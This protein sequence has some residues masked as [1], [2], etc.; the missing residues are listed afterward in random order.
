[1]PAVNAVETSSNSILAPKRMET[2]L[3]ESMISFGS[4]GTAGKFR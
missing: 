2:L 4:S 1:L 3:T